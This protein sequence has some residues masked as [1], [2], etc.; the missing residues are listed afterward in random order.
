MAKKNGNSRNVLDRIFPI[1][2]DFYQMLVEQSE[3]ITKGVKDF[4]KWLE[5]GHL[6][7]VDDLVQMEES[8]DN[9]RYELQHN[10]HEAFS[11]PFDREELY[12]LSRQ[13][14]NIINYSVLTAKQMRA[15]G[16][17]PD[18]HSKEMTKHLVLGMEHMSVAIRL[19]QEGDA[20]E[21]DA[22]VVDMRNSQRAIENL[23]IKAMEETFAHPDVHYV[24]KHSE[25]YRSLMETGNNLRICID[26]FHRVLV[27]IM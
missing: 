19:L 16:V 13:M 5:N 4:Q 14:D 1:E 3:Q 23:Y 26:M 21:A 15:Y 2:Y 12:S 9:T 11:T 22:K 8:L 27:G 25:V 18:V 6:S 10:L 7:E 17:P 20:A 24:L